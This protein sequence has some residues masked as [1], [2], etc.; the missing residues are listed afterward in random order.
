MS[1][2]G[3]GIHGGL[4][5]TAI[6]DLT[7]EGTP[8]KIGVRNVKENLV[9][10][11]HAIQEHRRLTPVVVSSSSSSSPN[12]LPRHAIRRRLALALLS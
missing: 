9:R 10:R 4:P 3:G 8:W 2:R 1:N 5:I 11:R 7:A 6:S 12:S